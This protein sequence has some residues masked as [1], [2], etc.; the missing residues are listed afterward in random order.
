MASVQETYGD[1]SGEG[2]D[3]E[4]FKQRIG[5]DERCA[6]SLDELPPQSQQIVMALVSQQ[7]EDQSCRNPSAMTFSKIRAVRERP[8]ELK[9]EY[10]KG[11]L[12]ERAGPALDGLHPSHRAAVLE[13]VDVTK[14]RNPSAVIWSK[15]RALGLSGVAGGAQQQS[16]MGMATAPSQSVSV[17]AAS[18]G[19]DDGARE[20]LGR[21][22]PSQQSMV[23]TDIKPEA[24]RNPSAVVIKKIQQMRQSGQ[25]GGNAGARDRSRTP[26]P[27]VFPMAPGRGLSS[28]DAAVCAS[29]VEALRASPG[30]A[31]AVVQA[32]GGQFV[33]AGPQH[34]MAMPRQMMVS[35]HRPMS[36]LD[37]R[38]THALSELPPDLAHM[39]HFLCTQENCK[40]PSAVAWTKVKRAKENPSDVKLEYLRRALDEG[41]L[42]A[43]MDLPNAHRDV[44]IADID[45]TSVRNLSAVIWSKVKAMGGGAPTGRAEQVAVGGNLDNRAT[46]ALSKLSP[47]QQ[48]GILSQMPENCKNP[49]AYVWSKV[50][51]LL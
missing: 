44:I 20:A 34:Q 31:P 30:A 50:K 23:L 13:K 32:L 26:P 40:N 41:A 37:D 8:E 28:H 16:G 3:P 24:C 51:G 19:L 27:Q 5:L 38:A 7:S 4:E 48:Q 14:C 49:S 21:L 22:S 10:I 47:S 2:Y 15:I 17:Q 36:G 6:K 1:D 42:K 45:V 29:V 43:L 33:S 35:Q 12:D 11:M 46:E 25:L 39:I 18:L 9:F